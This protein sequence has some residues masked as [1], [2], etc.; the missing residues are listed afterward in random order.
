MAVDLGVFG[1]QKT[2][3]DQQQLQ[4]AFNAKKALEAAQIGALQAKAQEAQYLDVDK[5]GKQSIFKAALGQPLSPEE[6]AAA[7]YFDDKLPAISVAP[8]FTA[9]GNALAVLNPLMPVFTFPVPTL[10]NKERDSLPKSLAKL[11]ILLFEGKL[12]EYDDEPPPAAIGVLPTLPPLSKLIPA[13]FNAS[14]PD[15]NTSCNA[16]PL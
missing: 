15:L 3:L 13:A 1:R 16:L 2:V 12:V 6:T 8:V 4:E 5:L 14:P 9:L 10:S 11:P 7:R